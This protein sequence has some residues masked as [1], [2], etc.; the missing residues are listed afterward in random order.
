MVATDLNGYH[1]GSNYGININEAV[2]ALYADG[3]NYVVN[4]EH[5]GCPY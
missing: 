4:D 5:Y 1:G 3:I 2:K